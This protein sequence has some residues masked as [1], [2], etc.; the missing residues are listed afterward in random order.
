MFVWLEGVLQ[1]WGFR[2]GGGKKIPEGLK[3]LRWKGAGEC[4][5]MVKGVDEGRVQKQCT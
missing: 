5:A 2:T 3:G 4:W 1:Y